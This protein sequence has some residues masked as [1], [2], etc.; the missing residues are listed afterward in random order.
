ML[1]HGLCHPTLQVRR[2]HLQR[3]CDLP[4]VPLL[5]P[6]EPG[7]DPRAADSNL[8]GRDTQLALGQWP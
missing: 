3:G 4:K 5:V 2:P 7:Q 8:Q 1:G 6:M